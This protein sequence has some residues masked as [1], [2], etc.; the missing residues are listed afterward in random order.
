VSA[1]LILLENA[2]V[3]EQGKERLHYFFT[4]G[5]DSSDRA[6]KSEKLYKPLNMYLLF[7][8]VLHVHLNKYFKYLKQCIQM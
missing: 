7:L 8:R 6:G 4:T 2:S 5:S 1:I 3:L